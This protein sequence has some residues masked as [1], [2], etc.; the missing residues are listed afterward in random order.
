ML[1][2]CVGLVGCKFLCGV[3]LTNG[4]LHIGCMSWTNMLA[5]TARMDTCKY[6][7]S[8]VPGVL[9]VIRVAF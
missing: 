9:V 3:C 2:I 7:T 5:W 4:N 8:A 1:R 6:V